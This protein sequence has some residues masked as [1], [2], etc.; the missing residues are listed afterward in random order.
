MTA[1][2]TTLEKTVL[3]PVPVQSTDDIEEFRK[4]PFTIYSN[5]PYWIPHVRQEVEDVFD[6][7]K[8]P[9]HKHGQVERWIIKNTSGQTVGRVA[10]FINDRNAHTFQQPTGG[11]GFFECIDDEEVAF[12]LFDQ[13]KAWLTERGME[14]MDGPINFG[15][16]DK[17][18]GLIIENFT[19]SPYANQGYNPAYYIKFF[20]NYGFQIYF[21]QLIFNRSFHDPLPPIYQRRVERLYGQGDVEIRH[22][23]KNKA[24][25]YAGYFMQIYNE[26]FKVLDNFKP[27]TEEQT[28]T[29]LE[30][31]K[32]II[33][34]DVLMFVFYRGQPAAFMIA[35]PNVNEIYQKVGDN[36]NWWGKIKFLYYK[37]VSPPKTVF[38]VTFGIKPEF[39][40]KGLEGLFFD[41]ILTRVATTPNYQY[42]NYIVSWVG[43]W[44]PKMIRVMEALGCKITRKMA[45]YRKLFDENAPFERA[46]MIT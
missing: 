28:F 31:I 2:T 27:I 11:M 17:F 37:T 45:T 38:G 10:A 16:R 7:D 20:E 24:R 6:A 15:E 35:L 46:P 34:S 14:A 43:D 29:T 18:W 40:R 9:F 4:L 1:Q 3:S 26:A 12:A 36:M 13:C 42:D 33:N 25:E 41:D 44:N 21:E 5:D 22:Y 32:P 39:Q 8:N 23:E 19:L 30:R